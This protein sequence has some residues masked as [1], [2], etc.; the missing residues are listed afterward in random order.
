VK[1]LGEKNLRERDP[2]ENPGV[3]GR[4]ILK[5]I[6]KKWD[7]GLSWIEVAQNTDGCRA[8]VNLVVN[9]QVP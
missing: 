1:G 2:L 4:I 7:G 5:S 6:F 9:L 3:D 8:V